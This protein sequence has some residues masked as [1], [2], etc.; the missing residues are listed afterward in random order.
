MAVT[1]KP[2]NGCPCKKPVRGKALVFKILDHFRV[3]IVEK[4][5]NTTTRKHN[6]SSSGSTVVPA[7][8]CSQRHSGTVGSLKLRSPRKGDK[9][10]SP[11][12]WPLSHGGAAL[13][14]FAPPSLI[15][16][17]YSSTVFSQPRLAA[18]TYFPLD[19]YMCVASRRLAP[20]LTF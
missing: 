20:Q 9:F 15:K 13:P 4:A 5:S 14:T 2:R 19:L 3:G 17:R 10:G 1:Y 12:I 7:K 6:S 11:G 16:G 8:I 18:K